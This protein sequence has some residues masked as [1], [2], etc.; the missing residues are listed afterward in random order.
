MD[1]ERVWEG[2]IVIIVL[3]EEV[4]VDG[5]VVAVVDVGCHE[6]PISIPLK[7]DR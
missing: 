6:I 5:I 4:L 3:F 1:A 7:Y 2:W